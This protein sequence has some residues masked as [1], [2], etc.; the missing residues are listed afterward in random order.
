MTGTPDAPFVSPAIHSACIGT[1]A[2]GEC[3]HRLDRY[4]ARC[5]DWELQWWVHRIW[6]RGAGIGESS[7]IGKLWC[8]MWNF[9][10]INA[11]TM[12][13]DVIS[14]RS[15]VVDGVLRW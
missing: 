1:R 10:D 12:I 14:L 6:S 15:I 7:V 11:L 3:V 4:R 13:L 8:V 2:G 9:E 5:W